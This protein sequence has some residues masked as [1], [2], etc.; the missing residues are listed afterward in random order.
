MK[1]ST[2]LLTLLAL[3]MICFTTSCE[4]TDLEVE[5]LELEQIQHRAPYTGPVA[6]N[7]DPL[8]LCFRFE[9]VYKHPGDEDCHWYCAG[10]TDNPGDCAIQ[11]QECLD[12]LL[13]WE[14]Y[15]SQTSCTPT[16]CWG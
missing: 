11:L 12:G 8:K 6:P 1:N 4:K 3:V 15:C 7:G 5:S 13:D 14:I 16:V 9:V 10:V 2:L